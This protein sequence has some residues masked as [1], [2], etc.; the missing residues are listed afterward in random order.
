MRPFPNFL[1][2]MPQSTAIAVLSGILNLYYLYLTQTMKLMRNIFLILCTVLCILSCSKDDSGEDNGLDTS[3]NT[4]TTGASAHEFLSENE[5]SEMFIEIVYVE[6]F[7]PTQAAIDNFVSFLESRLNKPGGIVIEQ[8]AITSPG[9]SEY[10]V[11]DVVD[12]EK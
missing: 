6:G 4:K 12:I 9:I 8:R 10:S 3:G 11:T 7:K 5:F 1:T 2:A